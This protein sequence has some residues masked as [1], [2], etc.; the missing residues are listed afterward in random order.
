MSEKIYFGCSGFS[1]RLWKG[2]F[3]PEELP[4]K[5]YLPY[6]AN[7]LDA[8]EINMTF[9]RKPLAKTLEKW[10]DST[11]PHFRFF[12]KMPKTITHIKKLVDCSGE[13]SAFC[14]HIAGGLREKLA[15]F[16][17]QLPPS[18]TNTPENTDRL[19]Q[20]V[21][22]RFS[23]VVEFR[24]ASWWTEDVQNTLASGQIAMSGVSIPKDIPDV[25][26]SNLSSFLYYRLHGVPTMFKSEY[27]SE[28]LQELSEHLAALP[29]E[30]FVFFNNTFGIA[31]IKNALELQRL[32]LPEQVT[33][34][35]T[36]E[37]NQLKLNL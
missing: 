25:V 12:I 9:Y 13:T 6:Y 16:L 20:T 32:L 34:P 17:Y 3:Y 33:P 26:I 35:V 30:K 11:P 18:F 14:D 27:S 7:R 2:F 29:G 24:H 4:A 5:D 19:L 23:N 22:S 28:F 31:G 21:D 37:Q 8:V 10:Y 1:E 15:G 36:N